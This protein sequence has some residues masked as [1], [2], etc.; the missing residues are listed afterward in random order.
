VTGFQ[1]AG[2][3]L[4]CDGVCVSEIAAAVGTPVYVYSAAAIRARIEEFTR[5]FQRC[6]HTVHYALK[7]NS[8]LAIARLVARAGCGADANS[9]GE[10]AVALRAG[11]APQRIV[12]TGVGKTR[13]ELDEALRVGIKA[14]NVESAGELERLEA[15]ARRRGTRARVAIRVNP[16]I[17]PGGH[18]YISTGL[19]SSKFGVA[20]SEAVALCRRA[21]QSR[22]LD[23]VG[24]HVHIGSQ[25]TD[26]D[27]LRR[28]VAVLVEIAGD[29]ARDGVRLAH[30]DVGG[31]LGISYD[32]TPAPSPAEYAAAIVPL[33]APLDVEVLLEPG[34]VLVGP[35]GVLVTRVVDVKTGADGRRVVVLDSGMT[36]LLRPALYG[37]F[38]RIDFVRRPARPPALCDLVGPLC[39]SSDILGVGRL[40]PHPLVDDLLAIFD[41][42]AYGSTMAS[43]YNRRPLPPEVLV[44][45]GRWRLIRRRQTLDDQLACEL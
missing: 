25:I 6:R 16:D 22:D 42:G 5:A 14:I 13:E 30:V 19:R 29:L 7:A 8:T 17:D 21:S 37:A 35:A 9:G 31:G 36:E 43:T 23:L 4:V 45:E 1:Y 18:P 3:E 41:V 34:R 26:L 28:A 27:P 24:L 15:A 44:E 33:L 2:D 32:G 12:L 20:R 40:L 38:H 11:F 10:L 39:E